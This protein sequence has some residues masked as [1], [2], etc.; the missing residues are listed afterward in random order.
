MRA[1]EAYH[2]AGKTNTV[3]GAFFRPK[4]VEELFD[5]A[6]DPDNVKN[7]ASDP[8][9]AARLAR[10]RAELSRQQQALRDCGFLPEGILLQRA[11]QHKITLYE[12][13]RSPQLYD[14]A[15]YMRAADLANF[16]QPADLPRLLE[17]LRSSDAG[18]RFWGVVGCIQLGE[19]A[20]TPEVRQYL[21]AL[22]G[23][24]VKDDATLEVRVTAALYLC[25]AGH[26]PD[27]ALRSLAE[28]I[29]QAS[30]RSPGKGRA[31][32]DVMLLGAKAQAI[33]GLLGAMKLTPKDQAT[34]ALFRAR[35]E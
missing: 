5:C 8:A 14:Q 26:L 31:W 20:A 34:L 17:L 3:T 2:K 29:A 6:S 4:P 16:A 32:A 24:D 25:Q 28:V 22:L 12:L 19:R 1:W 10:M 33:T 35:H 15:G 30:D 7:L 18:F 11:R 9:H 21:E 13:I 27:V 23:T